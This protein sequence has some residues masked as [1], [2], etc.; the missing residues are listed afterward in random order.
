MDDRSQGNQ[1]ERKCSWGPNNQLRNLTNVNRIE[2]TQRKTQ[3]VW[4]NED[5][6]CR[7]KVLSEAVITITLPHYQKTT[8]T[9]VITATT[10][11]CT[12]SGPAMTTTRAAATITGRHAGRL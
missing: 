3:E 12:A 8:R 1:H 7:H 11:T 4:G 6:A 5:D 9:N 2:A 10:T